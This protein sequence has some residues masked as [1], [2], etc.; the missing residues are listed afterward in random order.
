MEEAAMFGCVEIIR[1]VANGAIW[2]IVASRTL[3]S[4]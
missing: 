1:V 3:S 2:L 4:Y